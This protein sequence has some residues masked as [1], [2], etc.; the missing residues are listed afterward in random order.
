M[1]F[2]ATVGSP[3]LSRREMIKAGYVLLSAGSTAGTTEI[4]SE[5]AKD[6]PALGGADTAGMP[7]STKSKLI[8]KAEYFARIFFQQLLPQRLFRLSKSTV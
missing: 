8:M 6:G 4:E 1:S 2:V 5:A 3:P 7:P